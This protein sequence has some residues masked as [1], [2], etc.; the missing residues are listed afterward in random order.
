MNGPMASTRTSDLSPGRVGGHAGV[1]YCTYTRTKRSKGTSPLP[2]KP[3]L[4]NLASK[5]YKLYWYTPPFQPFS[6]L[7]R[8]PT[9]CGGLQSIAEITQCTQWAF[10]TP[11]FDHVHFGCTSCLF[12]FTDAI[13]APAA[14]ALPRCP[15]RHTVYFSH[16]W[17]VKC[18][19]EQEPNASPD[20][21]VVTDRVL[22]T[23][24][25]VMQEVIHL[26]AIVRRRARPHGT[27]RLGTQRTPA[28]QRPPLSYN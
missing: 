11:P 26:G 1:R 24:T 18:S 14:A 28:G 17:P 22:P 8:C 12:T 27:H 25:C 3:H 5:R 16:N 10:L 2:N 20:G 7:P 6:P 13:H 19:A 4:L 23:L 21:R 9:R 15:Q